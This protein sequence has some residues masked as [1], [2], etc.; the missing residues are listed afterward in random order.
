MKIT[1]VT[2]SYNQG[3]FLEETIQSIWSQT[4]DFELEHIIADGGSTDNSIEIIKKY[5][6]L[7]KSNSYPFKCKGVTFQWW[8][9]KD[10]GQVDAL[11]K[12]FNQSTGDI[13]G[14]L[15]SDDK[16]N[17]TNALQQV[18][19]SF[20]TSKADIVVGNCKIIDERGE[21]LSEPPVLSNEMDN[22][23][24]QENLPLLLD[25]CFIPQPA[26]F[27]K[28]ELFVK[29]G[30]ANFHY[31]MDW[32]LW[33]RS[34]KA[35]KTFFKLEKPIACFRMQKEGKTTKLSPRYFKETI[36]ILKKYNPQSKQIL[37]NQILL[38]KQNIISVPIVG[39]IVVLIFNTLLKFYLFIKRQVLKTNKP[40]FTK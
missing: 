31:G 5:D 23:K 39:N 37:I 36:E 8:S 35:K 28:K 6:K 7:Y 17:D 11:N 9:G 2:P 19:T 34:Y 32:D 22:S 29:L 33:I 15:N 24:L 26:T 21:V 30:I 40:L 13:L 18:V 25:V 10:R 16:Y 38:A 27:F 12:A 4:G 20:S 3:Q 1:V 14:W